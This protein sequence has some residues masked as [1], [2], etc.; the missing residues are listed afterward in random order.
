MQAQSSAAYSNY[1]W[2]EITEDTKADYEGA[3]R[4]WVSYAERQRGLADAWQARALELQKRLALFEGPPPPA[5]TAPNATPITLAPAPE[6]VN[7]APVAHV[8]PTL[9][10]SAALAPVATPAANTS[11][12][13]I[14]FLG[15]G[16]HLP[17]IQAPVVRAA[18]GGGL[19]ASVQRKPDRQEQLR[20]FYRANNIRFVNGEY[21]LHH[22]NGTS[23]NMGHALPLPFK[24]LWIKHEQSYR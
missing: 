2:P 22:P 11:A 14:P 4:D 23:T 20:S 17:H 21:I 8:A 13:P 7:V 9:I 6:S 5:P 12:T 15:G 16:A 10:S 19:S 3:I 18:V 24:D 1:Q